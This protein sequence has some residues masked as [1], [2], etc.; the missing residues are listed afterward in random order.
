MLDLAYDLVDIEPNVDYHYEECG[1]GPI[2]RIHATRTNDSK[3]T[4]IPYSGSS[5]T[6]PSGSFI[7]GALY[8]IFVRKMKFDKTKCSF[9]GYKMKSKSFSLDI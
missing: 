5:V 7:C 2:F 4:V 8:G 6:F 9:V 1:G 3:V